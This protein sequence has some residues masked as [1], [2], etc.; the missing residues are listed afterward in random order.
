MAIDLNSIGPSIEH[1][2][3]FPERAAFEAAREL[4]LPVTTHA[5]VWGATNDDGIRLMHE[6][7]FE[8]APSVG[9]FVYAETGS[10]ATALFEQLLQEGVIV[11]PLAAF[12]APGAIRVSVGTPDELDVFADALGRVLA[13]A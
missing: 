10:D 3:A 4:G 9:N 11:R 6:H 13:R 7:G 1:D 8:P 5:G 2:P 12:G